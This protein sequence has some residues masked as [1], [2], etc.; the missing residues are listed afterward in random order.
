MIEKDL[1]K[2]KN[3]YH[4]FCPYCGRNVGDTFFH[5]DSNDESEMDFTITFQWECESCNHK[6]IIIIL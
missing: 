4:L 2:L 1:E 3:A 5:W 6:V